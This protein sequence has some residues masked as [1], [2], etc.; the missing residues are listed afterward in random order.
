MSSPLK[1]KA[2]KIAELS[3][4]VFDQNFNPSC[5]RAGSKYLSQRLKGPAV[6]QYYGDPDFPKGT[7]IKKRIEEDLGYPHVKLFNSDEQYRVDAAMR[8]RKRGKG[9]PPKKKAPAAS[10][11]KKKK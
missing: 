3:A 5:A 6:V 4:K 10:G 11:N 1:L 9:A 7:H 8:K 2:L